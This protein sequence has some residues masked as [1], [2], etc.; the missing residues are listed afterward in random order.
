M[1]KYA[2]APAPL[3]ET[4][5]IE[6]ITPRDSK[7]RRLSDSGHLSGSGS[8][9]MAPDATEAVTQM[10]RNVVFGQETGSPK[11]LEPGGKA[12]STT[13]S[14]RTWQFG[15]GGKAHSTTSSNPPPILMNLPP[16]LPQT[17]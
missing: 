1:Q 6:D 7:A 5:T 16:P 14:T 17:L 4:V 2:V 12:H 8:G 11:F 13:S 9:P 3:E 15:V 10:V